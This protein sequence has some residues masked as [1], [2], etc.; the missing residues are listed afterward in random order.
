M[1][2]AFSEITLYICTAEA[3]T[4]VHVLQLRLFRIMKTLLYL[5]ILADLDSIYSRFHEF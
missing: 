1:K 3:S 5:R 4:Y 2:Y